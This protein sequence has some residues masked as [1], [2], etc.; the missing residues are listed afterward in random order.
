MTVKMKFKFIYTTLIAGAALLFATACYDYR[1]ENM[2]EYQTMVYFRNGG[3][4]SLALYSTGE[5]GYYA[6]PICKGGRNLEGTISVQVLAFDD[7]RVA[8]YNAANYTNYSAIPSELFSFL[9]EDGQTPIN[10]NPVLTMLQKL[11]T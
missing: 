1:N 5:D 3:E 6:I 4:Q 2:E 7:T 8:L 11:F 10:E 9:K